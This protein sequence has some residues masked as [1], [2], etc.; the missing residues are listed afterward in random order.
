M[1]L[2]LPPPFKSVATLLCEN[3]QH[4]QFYSTVNSDHSDEKRLIAVN[5]REE[6]YLLVFFTQ[7]NLQHVFKMS[8][9][10][11]YACLTRESHWSM[12]GSI[13]RCSMV[14]QTFIFITER[15]E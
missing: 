15:N 2:K 3:G 11:T 4:L 13:V 10:G 5:F 14:C 6:C 9:F 7:I 8:A 12:D 1:E